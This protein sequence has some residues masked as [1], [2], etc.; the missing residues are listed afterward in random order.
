[1]VRMT[2]LI[3]VWAFVALLAPADE[4]KKW[5]PPAPPEGWKIVTSQDGTF[6]FA[7]P[8]ATARTGTRD[9]TVNAG[10]VKTRVQI[11]YATLKDEMTLSVEAATL[12][13]PALKG[14]KTAD[15][16]SVF[17]DAEKADGFTISEPKDVKVGE[18]KAREYKLTKDKVSRRTVMFAVKPRIY[19]IN[20][21][22][23]DP[24]KLDS[25][26]ASTFLQSLVLVPSEVVKA[27][28]KEKAKKEV[29]A[30]EENLEKF[31]AKWTMKMKEMTPPDKKVTGLLFGREFTPEKVVYE[32]G[33][34]SFRIGEELIPDTKLDLVLFLKDGEK[35]ENKTINIAPAAFNPPNSPHIHASSNQKGKAPDVEGC[36][37]NYA[38]K[39]T[40]GEKDKSGEVP[41]TIYLCLPDKAKS[42]IAGTFTVTEK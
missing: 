17:L 12:T 41:G 24:E 38:L 9:R 14:I 21:S 30:G 16:L 27:A 13:G 26:T 5:Q 29:E 20:V 7:Q 6:M 19:L 31:G 3:G 33:W 36:V 35:L 42:F 18:I 23:A 2:S 22:A 25:E 1:M 34:L 37:S 40:F 4:P 32:N 11:N 39:L 28:A 10:G 15:V 8:K